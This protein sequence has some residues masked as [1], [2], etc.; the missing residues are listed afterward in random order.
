MLGGETS[1]YEQRRCDA[2][3]RARIKKLNLNG[4]KWRTKRQG[5][6]RLAVLI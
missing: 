4:G 3:D 2:V 6:V 1:G 5:S